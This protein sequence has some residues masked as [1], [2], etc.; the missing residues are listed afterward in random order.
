MNMYRMAAMPT[1]RMSVKMP[2]LRN[3]VFKRS[4]PPGRVAAA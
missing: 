4:K 3:R 2:L 1:T